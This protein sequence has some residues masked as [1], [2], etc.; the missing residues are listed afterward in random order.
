MTTSFCWCQRLCHFFEALSRLPCAT[1]VVIESRLVPKAL[2]SALGLSRVPRRPPGDL[3]LC[4]AARQRG[5]CGRGGPRRAAGVQR[6]KGGNVKETVE[7]SLTW[8]SIQSDQSGFPTGEI[9]PGSTFRKAAT[10]LCKE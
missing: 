6:R 7:A 1:L 4:G 9:D 3:P 5:G 10:G 2:G 8:R